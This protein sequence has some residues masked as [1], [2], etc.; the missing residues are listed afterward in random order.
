M[1]TTTNET[2]TN[3]TSTTTNGTTTNGASS[4]RPGD[5]TGRGAAP[6][7]GFLLSLLDTLRAR[8]AERAERKHL[9]RELAGYRTRS[10]RADL[11]AILDRYP[12][13]ETAR[14]RAILDRIDAA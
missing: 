12:D 13:A 4:S 1:T 8:R 3:G 5:P 11:V 9:E 14:V 6:A 2:R 10:E 7:V